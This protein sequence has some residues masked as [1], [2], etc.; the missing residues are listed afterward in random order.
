[1]PP[2]RLKRRAVERLVRN[3]VAKATAEY[4]KNKTKLENTR[5]SGGSRPK[6]TRGVVHGCS[7]KTFLNCKPYSFNGTE[8]VW[9]GN[10]QTLGLANANQI[11]WSNVKTMM[12]TEYCPTTGIQ[13]IE[14]ELWTLTVK[15]DDI[16]GKQEAAKAYFAAP[17]EGKGYA[18]NL[19]LC[20]RC[21]AHHHGPCPPRCGKCQKVGHHEKNC[22][23]RAPATGGNF[24]QNVTC[25]SGREK[26]HYRNK[27][28][29]GKDQ[30]NPNVVMGYFLLNNYYANILFDLGAEKSFVSTAFTPFIDIAPAV[31]ETSYDVEITDEKVVS[32]NTVLRGCTL[33]LFNHVFKIDLLPTR[34]GSFDVLVGMNWLSNHRAVIVCY[35][36]IV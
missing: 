16:E 34:L 23:V 12:T 14:Q 30:H 36:K 10:V 24:L 26:G 9:N 28:P 31:L 13:K 3:R 27:C 1:M 17:A 29:K 2:K 4:E 18:R 25:F 8:G 15:G 19:T 21:K 32:T 20:N 6:S 7:Y 11:S 33:A 35:E 22:R 5:G